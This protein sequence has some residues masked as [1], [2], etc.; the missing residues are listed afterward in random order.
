M[1]VGYVYASLLQVSVQKISSEDALRAATRLMQEGRAHAVKLEG[2]KEMVDTVR[3]IVSAG[4]PVM[5][6]IG[7]QPQ[8]VL[9]DGGYKIKG[10]NKFDWAK[11]IDDA[12]ALEEA[13]AFSVVLEGMAE[14]LAAEITELVS[15]PTIG[16]G[17][18]S[19]CDGQILVTEDMVGLTD[20]S[21]KFVKQYI[22]IGELIKDAAVQYRKEVISREFPTKNHVYGMIPT[23]V[24][25]EK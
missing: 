25:K 11:F 3:R 1:V 24:K 5:G 21:P 19:K 13:G 18:S 8:S 16:I 20:I 14:P 6:H 22:N 23:I 2:G 4:I 10:R 7:L 12:R 15:I 9:V 17:A